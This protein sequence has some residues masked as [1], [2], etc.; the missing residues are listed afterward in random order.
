MEITTLSA[1][2]ILIFNFSRYSDNIKIEHTIKHTNY[3]IYYTNDQISV[4]K[5]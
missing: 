1:N 2:G 4:N 3:L 5:F